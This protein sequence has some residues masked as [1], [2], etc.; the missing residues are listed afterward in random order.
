MKCPVCS[1]ATLVQA[2]RDL[3]YIFKVNPPCCPPPVAPSVRPVAKACSSGPNR[4][5]SAPRC[6]PFIMPSM[7][8]K[9][10]KSDV[11]D[12]Y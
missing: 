3:P 11:N 4:T 2:T 1:A 5:A 10:C 9:G 8:D 12:R 7:P 6:W